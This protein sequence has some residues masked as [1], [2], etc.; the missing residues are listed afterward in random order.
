MKIF[1]IF[2]IS[3]GKMVWAGAGTGYYRELRTKIVIVV[4]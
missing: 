2:E 4:I 1:S 3:L